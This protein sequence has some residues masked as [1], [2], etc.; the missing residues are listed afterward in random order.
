MLKKYFQFIK[1][2]ISDIEAEHHSLGEWVEDL[3]L[4]NKEILELIKPFVDGTNASVRI[5]NTINVL[6]KPKK[7]SIYK[8]IND[9]LNNTGRTTDIRTFVDLTNESLSED[10]VVGKN[11]FATFLK[12]ITSLDLKDIKPKWDNMPDD[13]LLFFEYEC[14]S[15]KLTQ[16]LT[17]RFS[18]FPSLSYFTAKIP[19]NPKLYYGIKNNMK[20]SFGFI[21]EKL[22]EIGSFII[23]KSSLNYLQLIDSK[24]AAHLKRELA[25]INADKLKFIANI[26]KHM[27]LYHPG[28]TNNRTFKINDGFLE[29]G[30][31]GLGSWKD[32]KIEDIATIKQGFREHLQK[33][34]GHENLRMRVDVSNDPT[35]PYFIWVVLEIK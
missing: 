16:K 27:K 7:A 11:V 1:E 6:D 20:F 13:F 2:K 31:Q 30:Y 26:S 35:K 17:D 23:N 28:N 12:V 32:G 4:G 29:F 15:Q 5:A 24:S 10:L 34:R 25:Y 18:I 33:L 9:Y 19:E 21:G 14:D 8:I 3:A 22:I